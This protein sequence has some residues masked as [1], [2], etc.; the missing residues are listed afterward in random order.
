MQCTYW[1][2]FASDILGPVARMREYG[3]RS[4]LEGGGGWPSLV[5]WPE[6]NHLLN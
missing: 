1:N 6:C 4:F 3:A 2:N 5:N